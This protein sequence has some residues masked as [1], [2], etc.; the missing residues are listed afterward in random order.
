MSL[1]DGLLHQCIGTICSVT[2]DEYLAETETVV[3]SSVPCR[4]EEKIGRTV[5]PT[6]D[7]VEYSNMV[8]ILPSYDV[9]WEYK[10]IKGGIDYKVVARDTLTDLFGD[11]DH[12]VLYLV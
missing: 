12:T 3:Y 2:T 7:V 1:V 5:G 8:F 9:E 10:I 4:W 11:R 6:G